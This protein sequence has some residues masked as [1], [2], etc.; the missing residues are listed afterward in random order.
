MIL[1]FVAIIRLT[2]FLKPSLGGFRPLAKL[3]TLKLL[4]G[5]AILQD[6]I[7]SILSNTGAI[8]AT[9]AT[10]LPDLLIGTPG[11]MICCE[12]FIFSLLF[13]WPYS[14]KSYSMGAIDVEGQ[15]NYHLGILSALLDV[16]NITDIISGVLY[17]I[18]AFQMSHSGDMAQLDTQGYGK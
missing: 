10:N 2:K 17:C 13:L 14:A 12:C 3:L 8:K 15:G 18:P 16:L 5:L 7:F 11:L 9:D 1:C 6:L 4:V